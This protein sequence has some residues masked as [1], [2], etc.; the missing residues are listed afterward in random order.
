M[1]MTIDTLRQ[2]VAAD[3]VWVRILEDGTLEMR[4]PNDGQSRSP[5]EK[6]RYQ[7]RIDSAGTP[8]RRMLPPESVGDAWLDSGTPE[9]ERID[10]IGP[11]NGPIWRYFRALARIA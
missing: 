9:W 6:A 7:Y 1:T 4:D 3:G 2:A 11:H 10:G 8:V 5:A